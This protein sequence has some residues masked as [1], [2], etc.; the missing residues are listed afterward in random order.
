M[1]IEVVI[2]NLYEK[3]KPLIR[4]TCMKFC[5]ATKPLYPETDASRIGIRHGLLQV[6]DGIN[7]E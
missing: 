1:D 4:N 7:C 5:W 3:E 2:P 6:K